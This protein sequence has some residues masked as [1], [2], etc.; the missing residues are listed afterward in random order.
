MK[1]YRTLFLVLLTS[2]AAGT[3]GAQAPGRGPGDMQ[4]ARL[5]RM[6]DG[7]TLS[8]A[9]HTRVDSIVAKYRAQMP[10]RTPG[11]RPA[12]EQMQQIRDLMGKQRDEIRAV[13]TPEQQATFDKNVGE[14]RRR[15]GD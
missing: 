2:I 12:P 6:L 7:I 13:L 10:Q 1:W 14:M 15:R 11:E 3:A 8:D 4:Q 5:R 9:Q